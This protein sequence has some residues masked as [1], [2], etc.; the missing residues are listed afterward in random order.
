MKT[1]TCEYKVYQYNELSEEAKEKAKEWYLK[2]KDAE[3]FSMFYK[4]DLKSIFPDSKLKLEF[5]LYYRQGDGLNIYGTVT[6]KNVLHIIGND[7]AAPDISEKFGK[8]LTEKEKRTVRFYCDALKMEIELPQ[9]NY[10]SAYC[11]A[12]KTE[13]AEEWIEELLWEGYANINKDV[14]FKFEKLVQEIFYYLSKQYEEYG[15][16]YFYEV[17]DQ[18]M[19]EMCKMN[20]WEFL[21]DGKYYYE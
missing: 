1:V 13:F 15:Y 5:S 21:E 16:E 19:E 12:D 9:N 11:V 18:E 17:D 2:G 4:D 8:Y 7:S 3:D 10:G 20:Q 14:L 6:G